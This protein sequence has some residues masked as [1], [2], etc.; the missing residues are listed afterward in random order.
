MAGSSRRESSVTYRR[1]DPEETVA[2][3]AQLARRIGERFPGSGLLHV[4]AELLALARESRATAERIARPLVALRILVTAL[5]LA[6]L[7]VFG[8]TLGAVDFRFSTS[9]AA[10]LVQVFE[11]SLNA[12]AL[13]GAAL[14]FLVTIENRVKRARALEA[15]HE[16]R[17]MAHVID[18]HQLTKDPKIP[19][20]AAV[21][22][23]SSPER[24]LDDYQLTRYL[25]YCSEMLALLGK[26]AALYAQSSTDREIAAAVNDIETLTSG[27]ARQIWDKIQ[28]I[29]STH[30]E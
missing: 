23:P 14:F 29:Y 11:A 20:V 19:G 21:S 26:I 16:L 25:D 15:L 17:S 27:L 22:T 30:R 18:M 3:V 4:C 1:L 5:L 6:I 2:T 8:Y 10:D 28:A 9:S 12:I 13:M 7:G 24:T